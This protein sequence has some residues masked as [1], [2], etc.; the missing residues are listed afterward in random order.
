MAKPHLDLVSIGHVD[1]GKSTLLGRLFLESGYVDQRVIDRYKRQAEEK[2]KSSFEYAWVMDD[3]AEERARGLTIRAQ[4]KQ[5]ESEKYAVT[6]SD[7]PGHLQFIENMIRGTRQADG[8]I[9]VV[10]ANDG[11]MPQT[12]EHLLLAKAFGIE[13][14][15]IAVNKM[16]AT[17]PKYNRNKYDVLKSELESLLRYYEFKRSN[18]AFIPVSAYQGDNITSKSKNMRWYEGPAL[19]ELIDT[20][21]PKPKPIDYPLRWPLHD[22]MKVEGV[23]YIPVGFIATG[24]MSVGD[25]LVFMPSGRRGLVRTMEVHNKRVESAGPGDPVGIDFRLQGRAWE[26]QK[27]LRSGHVAG[28]VDNPPSVAETF[29]AAIKVMD[30]PNPVSPG[31]SPTICTHEAHVKCMIESID[32]I[33]DPSSGDITS[34][35]SYLEQGDL[36]SVTFRPIRPLIVEQKDDIPALSRFAMREGRIGGRTVGAGVVVKVNKKEIK[37]R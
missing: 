22:I 20:F 35:K 1:H 29:K 9:V 30:L 2:G 13:Q 23:G 5:Y 8:A 32:G 10:A 34:E 12:K 24:I 14:L 31:Y 11:I 18:C 16:D 3:L 15:V 25:E 6:F 7:A 17:L 37:I 26:K 36:A 19:S 28:H 27:A 33:L 21:E 4:I